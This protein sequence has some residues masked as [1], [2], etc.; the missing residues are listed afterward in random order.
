MRVNRLLHVW[1]YDFYDMGYFSKYLDGH[2]INMYTKHFST[3]KATYKILKGMTLLLKAK[4]TLTKVKQLNCQVFWFRLAG[5]GQFSTDS[6][7]QFLLTLASERYTI[8]F[9]IG[10]RP[11]HVCVKNNCIADMYLLYFAKTCTFFFLFFFFVFCFVFFFCFF[12]FME[13]QLILNK[14]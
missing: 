11:G 6:S 7:T 8:Y 10:R 12:F 14:L 3:N 2:V 5:F 4:N 13:A 1:V 9:D